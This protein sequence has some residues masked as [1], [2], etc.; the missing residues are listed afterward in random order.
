VLREGAT[1]F[2]ERVGKRDVPTLEYEQVWS[3]RGLST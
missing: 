3:T 1:I 2:R